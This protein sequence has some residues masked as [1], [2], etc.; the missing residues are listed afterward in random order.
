MARIIKE[1]TDSASLIIADE[2][3][4]SKI[5]VIRGQKVMLDSDLADLYGVETKRLKEQVRRNKH[6]FPDRFM[7]ELR[8]EEHSEI[9]RSQNATLESGNYSKYLPFVFTEHGVLMLSNILKSER[10]IN[11]SI[12]IIDIFIRLRETIADYTELKLDIESIKN[13]ITQQAKRQDNHD[14]NLELVF[15]YLDELTEQKVQTPVKRKEI[16]YKIGRGTK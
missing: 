5:Y 9:L 6:R 15:R 12:R 14:K 4:I 16:G 1:K 10:A 8:R 13:Q 7:F 3:V 2:V 11:M